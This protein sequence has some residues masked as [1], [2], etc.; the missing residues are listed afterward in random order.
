M[1]ISVVVAHQL[2]LFLGSEAS[3]WV[4]EIYRSILGAH[5]ETDLARWVGWDSGVSVS[6]IWE[7]LLAVLLEG[8]DQFKM[9]PLILGCRYN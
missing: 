5:D 2:F 9:E 7:H 8:F 6:N 3:E 1:D 4:L